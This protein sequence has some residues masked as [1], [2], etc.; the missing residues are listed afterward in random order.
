MGIGRDG[1]VG[2]LY[3]DLTLTPALT[4][5]L[6]LTLTLALSSPIRP[7]HFRPSGR[8]FGHRLQ[9]EEGG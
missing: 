4:P 9:D 6:T 3:T 7:T 2:P 8:L 1:R 5:N